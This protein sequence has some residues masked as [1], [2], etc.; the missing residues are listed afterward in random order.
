MTVRNLLLCFYALNA[1]ILIIHTSR[2]TAVKIHWNI[3]PRSIF[4]SEYQRRKEPAS[5]P[6]VRLIPPLKFRGWENS[7]QACHSPMELFFYFYFSYKFK[8]TF[9]KSRYA[10]FP[11]IKIF[12]KHFS[13]VRSRSN[14]HEHA[15]AAKSGNLCDKSLRIVALNAVSAPCK[16]VVWP[17]VKLLPDITSCKQTAPT[18]IKV[19][20]RY[21]YYKIEL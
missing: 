9:S 12:T 4:A 16:Q 21:T 19:T 2:F 5:S 11:G 1:A 15:N 18:R 20:T 10:I 3:R 14:C 17:H 6:N 7:I 13:Y 8:Y